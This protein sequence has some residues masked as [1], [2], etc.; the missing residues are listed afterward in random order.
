MARST[1]FSTWFQKKAEDESWE[2]NHP[3][4]KKKYGKQNIY[5][6]GTAHVSRQSVEAVEKI[7]NHSKTS[8]VCVELCQNRYDS[9][10]DKDKW[11]KL[12]II[13][14]IKSKKIYLL[15]SSIILSAFQKQMGEKMDIRPGQ[16]MIT[17]LEIAQKR[18]IPIGLVDRDIQITLKRAWQNIGFWGKMLLFSEILAGLLFRFEIE[19]EEIENMKRK[20]VLEQL[21]DNL[22][23]RYSHIKKIIID[24]RDQYLAQKIKDEADQH[25]DQKNI[26]VV[27]G[28]GHL[29]G[30]DHYFE[31]KIDLKPLELVKN[32]SPWI[33][34][35]KFFIPVIL[36]MTV[37]YLISDTSDWNKIMKSIYAWIIIKALVS[38][39]FALVI[40]AH[41]VALLGAFLTAP[42][43]NFNPVLK[44]GWVSALAEAH[45]RKPT[46]SDFESISEDISSIKKFFRNKVLR[47]FWL[48]MMPQLGSS[49]GTGIA[50][51]YISSI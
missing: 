5:I 12:D 1:L 11:K 21:L 50:L 38:G 51:W 23:R 2:E 15:M 48:V 30:I 43:S 14:V 33:A 26:L 47:I 28:A 13:S 25:P 18:E 40:L 41:P 37:I 49:L 36:L 31:E 10:M 9:I 17:A 32:K 29:K 19:E 8:M 46:V 6:L 27:V 7:A 3:I 16:E 45:F 24:E 35:A 20:D 34:A 39:I 42:I 22:P 4:V 44:P